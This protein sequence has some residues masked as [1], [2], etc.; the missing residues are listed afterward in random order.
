MI[1][2]SKRARLLSTTM[3]AG[4]TIVIGAGAWSEAAAQSTADASSQADGAESGTTIDDVVV[5]GSR[6]RRSD[7]ASAAPVTFINPEVFEAV[8]YTHLTLP[9]ICSV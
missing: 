8:S 6:I 5:T 2:Q 1:V 7:A 4:L 9:T 3:V